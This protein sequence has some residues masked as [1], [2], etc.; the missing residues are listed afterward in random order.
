MQHWM[1]ASSCSLVARLVALLAVVVAE[2]VVPLLCC[3]KGL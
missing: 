1:M 2:L 3:L